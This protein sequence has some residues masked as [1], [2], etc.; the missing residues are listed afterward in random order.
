MR[1]IALR[2]DGSHDEREFNLTLESS[3]DAYGPNFR[4][5]DPRTHIT[6]ICMPNAREMDALCVMFNATIRRRGN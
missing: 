1:V 2:A 3:N 4:I 6:M 5:Q